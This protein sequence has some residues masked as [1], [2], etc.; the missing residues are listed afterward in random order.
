MGRHLHFRL[1]VIL[2][3]TPLAFPLKSAAQAPAGVTRTVTDETGAAIANAA[4]SI[5]QAQTNLERNARTNSEGRYQV[6][7]LEVGVYHITAR[8]P[9]FKTHVLDWFGT[10]AFAAVNRFGNMPRNTVIGPR[11]DN[12]DVSIAKTSKRLEI[13]NSARTTKP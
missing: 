3:A 10:S 9:G 1:P 13:H 4:I 12:V 6:T 2:T 11:F 7:A 5:R 8:A